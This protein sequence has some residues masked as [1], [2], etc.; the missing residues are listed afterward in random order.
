MVLQDD[1]QK[2][3]MLVI[4]KTQ[5]EVKAEWLKT[6]EVAQMTEKYAQ[7]IKSATQL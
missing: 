1:S 4:E 7:V 3:G 5:P 2:N 6:P